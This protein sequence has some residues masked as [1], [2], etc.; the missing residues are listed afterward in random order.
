MTR[1]SEQPPF[2]A[3]GAADSVYTEVGLVGVC[4]KWLQNKSHL[5]SQDQMTVGFRSPCV[6]ERGLV[7]LDKTERGFCRGFDSHLTLC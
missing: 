1:I 3:A 2:R 7:F 6:C 4:M 5:M